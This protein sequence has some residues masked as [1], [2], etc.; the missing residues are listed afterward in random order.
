V[1]AV[2]GQRSVA[3]GVFYFAV[4]DLLFLFCLFG[5]TVCSSVEAQQRVRIPRLGALLYSNPDSDPNFR[6][7]RQGLGEL[8]Y[9]E[10]ENLAIEHYFADGRPERLPELAAEL[11]RSK[12]DVILTLAAT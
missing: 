1:K 8:G 10:R 9:V 2:I 3:G 5:V 11:V 6:A 12:P 7:F 4:C